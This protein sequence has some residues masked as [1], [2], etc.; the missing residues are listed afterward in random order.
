MMMYF[1][2]TGLIV[3]ICVAYF[4]AMPAM[5]AIPFPHT[6][7]F[8]TDPYSGD[9]WLQD[10]GVPWSTDLALSGS[11]SM[12]LYRDSA[13]SDSP[14]LFTQLSNVPQTGRVEVSFS[15]YA[16]LKKSV[17]NFGLG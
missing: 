11:H 5:A 1:K 4:M 9:R 10:G 8:E 15:I 14:R 13:H 12:Y 6:E 16:S 7:D 3:I 17:G 2:Q